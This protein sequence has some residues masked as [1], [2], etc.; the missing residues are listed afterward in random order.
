[1]EQRPV[2]EFV[3]IR[4]SSGDGM[5]KPFFSGKYRISRVNMAFQANFT[6]SSRY[7]TLRTFWGLYGPSVA[8]LN[9]LGIVS[10][11]FVV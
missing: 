3:G 9:F 8:L 6:G 11:K 5:G 7:I 4:V 10:Y 2:V 1:M